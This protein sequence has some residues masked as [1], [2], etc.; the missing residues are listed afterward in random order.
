MLS[1]SLSTSEKRAQLHEAL[2]PLA[3]FAQ[4][5]YPLLIAH[6]DDGGREPG[7]VFT[8]KHKVDPTS[9]RTL[10]DFTLALRGLQSVG[11]ID[12]KTQEKHTILVVVDFEKHQSLRSRGPSTTSAPTDLD[13]VASRQDTTSYRLPFSPPY[14]PST[15]PEGN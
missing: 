5:L 9:P 1:K 12:L 8:V 6:A 3:E 11:L 10:A 4:A 7:D 2:G 13:L 14:P 15:P